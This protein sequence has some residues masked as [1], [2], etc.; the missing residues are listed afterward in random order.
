MLATIFVESIFGDQVKERGNLFYSEPLPCT[1][2][3]VQAYA[4]TAANKLNKDSENTYIFTVEPV[5]ADK[6]NRKRKKNAGA[7]TSKK[8]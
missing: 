1:L 7:K 4:E 6:K 3:L 8:K 2:P 5:H